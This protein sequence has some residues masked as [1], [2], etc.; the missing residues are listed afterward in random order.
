MRL[1]LLVFF[2]SILVGIFAG[3]AQNDEGAKSEAARQEALRDSAF[4]ELTET[5]DRAREV[6][7]LQQNRKAEI[8]ALEEI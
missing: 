1:I 4:G 6:E 3:C 5:L 2:A 7:R 8:D